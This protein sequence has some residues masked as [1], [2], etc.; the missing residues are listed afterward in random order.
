MTFKPGY[1]SLV[2]LAF[3][4]LTSLYANSSPSDALANSK[5]AF[6]AQSGLNRQLGA[7]TQGL[8]REA[9]Y[10]AN[11]L[12]I[13]SPIIVIGVGYKIYR[14]KAINFRLLDKDFTLKPN[15]AQI[16]IHF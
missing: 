14:D 2:C 8:E 12:G 11:Q 13:R 10:R 3:L 7:L 9:D 4:H 1:W 16:K 5:T 6:L 15:A